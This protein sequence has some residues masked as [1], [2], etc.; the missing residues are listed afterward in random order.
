MTE[1]QKTRAIMFIWIVV[2]IAIM[3][4]GLFGCSTPR[5]TLVINSGVNIPLV[6]YSPEFQARAAEELRDLPPAC[7]SNSSGQDCSEVRRLVSDYGTLREVVR[8]LNEVE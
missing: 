1:D 7:P 4:F 8:S 6:E 5:E 2:L 3:M